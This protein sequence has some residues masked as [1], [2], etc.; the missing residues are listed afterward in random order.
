MNM[1]FNLVELNRNIINKMI[2]FSCLFLL[3]LVKWIEEHVI[4][5]DTGMSISVLVNI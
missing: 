1:N 2:L 5:L 3:I 4:K